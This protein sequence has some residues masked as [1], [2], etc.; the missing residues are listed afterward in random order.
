M[1]KDLSQ[2]QTGEMPFDAERS[3][4]ISVGGKSTKDAVDDLKKNYAS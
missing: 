1:D 2:K 4:P 3:K